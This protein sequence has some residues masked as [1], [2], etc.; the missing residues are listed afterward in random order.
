MTQHVLAVNTGSSTTKLGVF[1]VEG[2]DARPVLRARLSHGPVDLRIQ[3]W[4]AEGVALPAPSPVRSAQQGEA[5][6][7]L[8]TL[9]EGQLETPV[10]A[11]GHRIVHGG[12]Q[13]RRPM[14]LT[15]EIA[16]AL[17][18]LAPLAPLHQLPALT[19]AATIGKA[20][21]DL[22]QALAFDTAFHHGHDPVV[23]RLGLPREFEAQG[24]RR[25][26]F[27]GLSYEYLAGRLRAFDP[28]VAGG[29]VIAAHLG[30]GASLCALFGGRSVDTT[31]GA[32]PLEGLLMGTRCGSIDP[33]VILYLLQVQGLDG[34]QLSALLYERS[35]LFGVSGLSADMRV[36]LQSHEASAREAI[37]LF[38]F[39]VAREAAALAGTLGGLDALIFTAGVGENCPEVRAAICQRLAWLGVQL[40]DAA[41]RRGDAKIST[42][43][44]GVAVWVIPT[45]EE[46]MI[47]IHTR[48]AMVSA[49]RS[50]AQNGQPALETPR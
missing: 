15:Q 35:G 20:R 8:L 33:G 49:P 11:V 43:G 3:A 21:P 34:S 30:S 23:D 2:S 24:L 39:R 41:N 36:L 22:P 45:D 25:F 17:K 38:V 32:T 12:S 48:E 28:S 42:L 40:D 27:H 7:D 46:Q 31:M 6:L 1:D 19:L 9:F 37:E 4:D 16:E 14:I 13:F 29:R 50:V 18:A 5:V 44:S 26:G 10:Q 47:A